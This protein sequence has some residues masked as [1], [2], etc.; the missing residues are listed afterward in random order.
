MNH[1]LRERAPIS[2]K[3]WEE[4]DQEARTRLKP[5]LA[6]RKL[7][8][9]VGPLGWEHSATNL[10]RSEPLSGSPASGAVARRR[11]VLPLIELR[12]DFVLSREELQNI[13][14]GAGDPDL[15]AVGEAAYQLAKAENAA[16][17]AGWPNVFTGIVEAAPYERRA[18]GNDP[19]GYPALIA[20]AVDDLRRGGVVGPYGLALNPTAHQ[21]VLQTVEIGGVLLSEHL[22]V[23]LEGGPIV[24]TPGLEGGAVVSLRG[25]DFIFESGQDISVGYDSH[26]VENVRLYLQESFSAHIDSPEAAVTLTA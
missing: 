7:V 22:Q 26:D 24:W 2:N 18:L 3:A 5:A 8:D 19:T 1:L 4:I 13:D 6:A 23:I 17:L 16:V 10:G 11:Q 12:A 25:G 9:F 20:A 21:L 14:R 15:D